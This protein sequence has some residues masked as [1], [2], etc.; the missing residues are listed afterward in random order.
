MKNMTKLLFVAGSGFLLSG[1]VASDRDMSTLKL[2]LQE[3]NSTI[4]QMQANQAELAGKMDE[5]NHNLSVSN[6]NLS[7]VDNQFS[8]L[9]AKLD[10][11]A[12][13]VRTGANSAENTQQASAV[14]PSDLF[15]QA[16]GLL[17]KGAFDS[18]ATG[19]KLYITN[20]PESENVEQAYMYMGDAYA[21]A[22]QT[23]SAAV[24]YATI[25]QKF[26]QSKLIPSA[27]LKYARSIVPL[28]KTEEAKKYL[29][30][31]IKDFPATSEAKLAKTELSKLK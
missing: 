28:G 24:A 14:L 7:Q 11:I 29:N 16:K 23:K 10:D 18:A 12:A 27:R 8:Q 21:E 1:C 19:F 17:D 2:Q 26:P 6:E 15:A 9:S 22:G 30:S 13:S 31:I 25:L 20:Y 4:V 3:L 5:L